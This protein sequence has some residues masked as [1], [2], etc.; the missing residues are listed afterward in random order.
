[1]SV[2]CSKIKE[3]VINNGILMETKTK[4]PEYLLGNMHFFLKESP[5]L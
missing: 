3:M 4:T 1:M 5:L 2:W